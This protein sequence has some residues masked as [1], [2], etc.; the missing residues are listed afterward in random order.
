MPDFPDLPAADRP[1]G[2][3]DLNRLARNLLERGLPLL[4][5]V[6]EISNLARPASG[7]LYFTLK[8]ERAQVRCTM[9]RGRAQLL[10]FKLENGMRV[11]ASATVTLYEPR[12]DFQLTVDSLRAGGT[13]NLFEAFQRLKER[14][15]AEGLFN[16][17][18]RRPL[19][20]YPERIGIVTSSAAAALQDVLAALRR[21]APGIEVVLYP[22]PVQGEAAGAALTAA[23][24]TASR[25]VRTDRIE[26][27]LVV[28]GGGSLEDLWAFNDEQLARAI[29]R[30]PV[31]VVS[32]VGHETD[33]TIAD[34]A[35]DLRAPTP[36]AAAELVSAGYHA[37][38]SELDRL[39]RALTARLRAQL[40]TAAQRTDRAA[41]RL[42]H[43]RD[44]LQRSTDHL[45]RIAADMRSLLVRRTEREQARTQA[46]ELRLRAA[47]PSLKEQGAHVTRLADRLAAAGQALLSR[48]GER[49]NSLAARLHALSPDATLARGFSIAR[50]ANGAILRDAAGV[51]PGAPITVQL[52]SGHLDAEV[53]D[54]HPEPVAKPEPGLS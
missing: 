27:L 47:R 22:A 39:A 46:L 8:D 50:D 13:G 38:A 10:P 1:L 40:D 52:A 5:V 15:A 37:A 21:R 7:H 16:E 49:C 4:R 30:A 23:V 44:R 11:E 12:G 18:N 33:F 34:F 28:R 14:L 25:R 45:A 35:A 9:W 54:S 19:P 36:T 24:E 48:R 32:G 20:R 53:R 41:L 17:E 43:P 6:G 31:P 42:L 51:A 2:V 26:A 3:S 29:R